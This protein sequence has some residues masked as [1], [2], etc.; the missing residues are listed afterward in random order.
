VSLTSCKLQAASAPSPRQPPV[1]PPSAQPC[2]VHR[3]PHVAVLSTGDEVCEPDATDLKLGQIRW[4]G[5]AAASR[6]IM[7]CWVRNVGRQQP[8]SSLYVSKPA[9]GIYVVFDTCW[10]VVH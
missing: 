10:A 4:V 6:A 3:K 5:A 2:R 1:P 7:Q 9:C 8:A